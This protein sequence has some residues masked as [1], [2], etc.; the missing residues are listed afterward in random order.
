MNEDGPVEIH[1]WL[2]GGGIAALFDNPDFLNL[3]IG[4][5]SVNTR[6]VDEYVVWFRVRCDSFHRTRMKKAWTELARSGGSFFA[7]M[8]KDC[9]KRPNFTRSK[10]SGG[11][12][13]TNTRWSNVISSVMLMLGVWK[14]YQFAT[15]WLLMIDT[16]L[17]WCACLWFRDQRPSM[18]EVVVPPQQNQLIH[19]K[20][21]SSGIYMCRNNFLK[22]V[23]TMQTYGSPK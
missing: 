2:T 5:M 1:N 20:T 4:I 11:W 23:W 13:K 12:W 21:C 15:R 6:N 22:R 10:K 18:C 9:D 7:S 16:W 17:I 14:S 8:L 3:R 19:S